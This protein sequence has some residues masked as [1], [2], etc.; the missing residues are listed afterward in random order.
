MVKLKLRYKELVENTHEIILEVK[1]DEKINDVIQKGLQFVDDN[2]IIES[3]S[4][5][6]NFIEVKND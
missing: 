3:N 6:I 4:I 5:T 1:D 2:T